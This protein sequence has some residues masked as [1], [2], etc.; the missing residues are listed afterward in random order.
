M[1][2]LEPHFAPLTEWDFAVFKSQATGELRARLDLVSEIGI[3]ERQDGWAYRRGGVIRGIGAISHVTPWRR[4][5]W[6]FPGALNG[7]DWKRIIRFTRLR[8]ARVLADSS[9][10]RLE[11][12]ARMDC[13]EACALLARLGFAFE[14]R[15]DGYGPGGE[16]HMMFAIIPERG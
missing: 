13:P 8:I 2:R 5:L 14:A 10:Y 6:S 3:S 16:A 15:L 4:V 9:L 1:M 11:A 7:G 12:T